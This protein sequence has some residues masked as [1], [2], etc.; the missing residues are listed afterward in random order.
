MAAGRSARC[1]RV[2]HAESTT[3]SAR[4]GPEG[5][6]GGLLPGQV[7]IPSMESA[8][9]RSRIRQATYQSYRRPALDPAALDASCRLPPRKLPWL[10][11]T[12]G[13]VLTAFAT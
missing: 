13:R 12:T 8:I 3:S 2:G 1:Q 10:T 9:R 4:G 7:I 6:S 5:P 11:P